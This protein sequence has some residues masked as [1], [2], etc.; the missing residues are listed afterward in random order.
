MNT[1]TRKTQTRKHANTQIRGKQGGNGKDKGPH[2]G[3]QNKNKSRTERKKKAGA[4][5]TR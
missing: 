1:Q 5:K 3:R 4:R 2:E